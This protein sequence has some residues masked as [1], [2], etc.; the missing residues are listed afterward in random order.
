M[1]P[2]DDERDRQKEVSPALK[3]ARICQ[4][5]MFSM[6]WLLASM[7]SQAQQ[8]Q[9]VALS[10]DTASIEAGEYDTEAFWR[11]FYC[12]CAGTWTDQFSEVPLSSTGLAPTSVNIDSISVSGDLGDGAE[13]IDFRLSSASSYLRYTGEYD[14]SAYTTYTYSS[15]QPSL[16]QND[17]GAFG[18][19]ID[20][21]VPTTVNYAPTGMDPSAYWHLK[22]NMTVTYEDGSVISLALGESTSIEEIPQGEQQ[23]LTVD[24]S[25]DD[26]ARF[27]AI[28]IGTRGGSG[29][30]DLFVGEGFLPTPYQNFSC[31]SENSGNN[32]VC[33][34][35]EPS[36]RYLVSV[37]GFEL[38]TNV[39][40]YADALGPPDAPVATEGV[41]ADLGA[42]VGFESPADNGASISTYTASCQIVDSLSDSDS[43]I[44]ASGVGVSPRDE[45]TWRLER[46]PESSRPSRIEA[47]VDGVLISG[48]PAKSGTIIPERLQLDLPEGELALNVLAARVTP[49]DNVFLTGKSLDGDDFSLLMTPDRTAIGKILLGGDVLLLSPTQEPG[50]SILRSVAEAGLEPMP[51]GEDF[52]VPESSAENVPLLEPGKRLLRPSM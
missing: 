9:T 21:Y 41:A 16:T 24:V 18:F 19:P 46:V 6:I 49:S 10:P 39:E 3:L 27:S 50:L 14:T 28:R 43:D 30:V 48:P 4:L 23:K 11:T 33:E 29:E 5:S 25:A 35:A 37:Y 26:A 12:S 31:S 52:V 7:P 45:A 32:E 22:I 40:V 38:S 2:V 36:G 51:L 17:E 1:A 20:I 34:L 44:D 47:P 8:L 13:F 15:D 42:E